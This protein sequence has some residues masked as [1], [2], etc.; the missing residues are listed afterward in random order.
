MKIL[1]KNFLVYGTGLSGTSA[2]SFLNS[3]GAKKVYVYDDNEIKEIKNSYTL[4]NLNDLKDLDIECVILS[5][6][7]QILGNKNI[8]LF[9][10]LNIPY[11]SEFYLGYL[12]CQGKKICITGTNGKTTTVN[13]IYEMLKSSF[14]EVYLC[15]NTDMPITKV[16]NMTSENSLIVCEVSSFALESCGKQFKPY[17][18]SILNITND[19]IS[20][21]GTFEKYKKLKY[22]VTNYQDNNDYF[23]ASE[24]FDVVTNAKLLTYSLNS[25]SSGAYVKGKYIYFNKHKIV[26]KKHIN[27]IGQKNLE[28]VLCAVTIAKIL[29]VKNFII[30]RAIKNFK[31]MKHRMQNVYEKDGVTYID[32][33]KATNP[34]STICALESFNNNVILLLGGSDKGYKYDDIFKHVNNVKEIVTFGAMSEKIKNT[35]IENQFDCVIS[36]SSLKQAIYYA[37]KV[38][39]DGDTVLLSPSCASFDEFSSYA[40]RGEFFTRLVKEQNEE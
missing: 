35:A 4:Y 10:K 16:A 40:E 11:I 13:L 1:S 9:K 22:L 38:A 19:H 3:R 18:S 8:E 27:L 29:K 31:G 12:F 24:N 32:D 17:I 2:V 25:I 14:N 30:K 5:P 20:R 34:D 37:K 6:G 23:V 26:N 21:H 15:G 33:S 39:K 36:F 28:N 7:V